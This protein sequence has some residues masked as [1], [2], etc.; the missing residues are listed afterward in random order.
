MKVNGS[1][2]A[3]LYLKPEVFNYLDGDMSDMMW[4]DEPLGKTDATMINWRLTSIKDFGNA[5]MH[6]E[7]NWN[8][9]HSGKPTRQN[10][11]SGNAAATLSYYKGKE[12]FYNRSY[13]F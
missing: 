10:G 5:W 11:K 1:M 9:N 12:G 3:F 13:R 6:C 8:W 7:I 2:V 4:E